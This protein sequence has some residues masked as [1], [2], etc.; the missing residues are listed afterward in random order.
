MKIKYYGQINYTVDSEHPDIKYMSDWKE[1]KVYTFS[2]VYVFDYPCE[3]EEVT[4]YIVH[5]LKLVAGGGYN[6][7][8]IHNLTFD[9]HQV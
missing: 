6:S 7:H 8:H 9:I 4:N 3:I 5:D 2:D 1:D